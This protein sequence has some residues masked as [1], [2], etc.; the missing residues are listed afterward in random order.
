M[1]GVMHRIGWRGLAAPIVLWLT[2]CTA[3]IPDETAPGRRSVTPDT[4][5]TAALARAFVDGK[6]Q[7]DSAWL[8]Q[9]VHPASRADYRRTAAT[10]AQSYETIWRQGGVPEGRLQT[11]VARF[12][13][14]TGEADGGPSY[15]AG[16]LLFFY[17]AAPSHTLSISVVTADGIET[18]VA[19]HAIRRER[20]RWYI[21]LPSHSRM[22]RE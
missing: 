9:I 19:N 15:R 21:V 2:A 13:S 17:P 8:L 10:E 22:P 5:S 14:A 4:P 11:R 16:S 7:H 6:R 12:V 3:A 20:G 18:Y 1:A